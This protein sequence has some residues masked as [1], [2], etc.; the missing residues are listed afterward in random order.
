MIY[1]S[2]HEAITT[3][4]IV[5]LSPQSFFM[6][7]S[8][9]SL[10]FL[11]APCPLLSVTTDYMC[12]VLYSMIFFLS[13]Y[14]ITFR[15]I[16]IVPCINPWTKYF[17]IYLGLYFLSIILIFS[18]HRYF[19]FFIRIILDISDFYCYY[20]QCDF[21]VFNSSSNCYYYNWLV[22]LILVYWF[23]IMCNNYNCIICS[24]AIF[25]Y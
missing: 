11:H 13:Q 24:Y 7:L 5:N 4:K 15:F 10:L 1:T 14:I 22:P 18:M 2:T 17:S 12:R 6:L 25:T 8:G 21:K 9:P 16:Y 19:T 20:K 23:A 3:I